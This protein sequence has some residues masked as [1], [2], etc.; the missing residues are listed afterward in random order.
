[1]LLLK[2]PLCSLKIDRKRKRKKKK[3]ARLKTLTEISLYL[4]NMQPKQKENSLK[5]ST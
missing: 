2:P 1:M 5:I 3:E 4:T